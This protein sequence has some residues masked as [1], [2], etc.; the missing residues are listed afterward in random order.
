MVRTKLVRC[1][2]TALVAEASVRGR[3]RFGVKPAPI[4][5]SRDEEGRREERERSGVGRSWS[6]FQDMARSENRKLT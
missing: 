4:G 6:R 5:D 1:R 3:D 2:C